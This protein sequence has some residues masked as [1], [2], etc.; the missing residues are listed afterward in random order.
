MLNDCS[1]LVLWKIRKQKTVGVLVVHKKDVYFVH[2]SVD[3]EP[4]MV[5]NGHSQEFG[6][7]E[8]RKWLIL[9]KD[10]PIRFK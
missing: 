2:A 5:F 4:E 1:G 7:N 3:E 10:E 6:N 8:I 9:L